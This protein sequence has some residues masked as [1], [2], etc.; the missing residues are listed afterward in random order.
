MKLH[1]EPIIIA[2]L[3][4]LVI[5]QPVDPKF[6]VEKTSSNR[7]VLLNSDRIWSLG[8]SEYYGLG[9]DGLHKMKSSC[10]VSK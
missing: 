10:V 3:L 5:A 4:L 1:I 6:S 2:A 8:M 7:A 9:F